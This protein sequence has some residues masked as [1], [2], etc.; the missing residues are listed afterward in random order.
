MEQNGAELR[1]VYMTLRSR[2][3]YWNSGKNN[4]K[5]NKRIN[6]TENAQQSYAAELDPIIISDSRDPVARIDLTMSPLTC[7]EI[8]YAYYGLSY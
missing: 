5:R 4:N 2:V 6:I 8:S 1:E 7:T 3:V